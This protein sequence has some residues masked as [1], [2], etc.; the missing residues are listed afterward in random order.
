MDG[1]SLKCENSLTDEVTGRRGPYIT[2]AT[3]EANKN[4]SP[5]IIHRRQRLR[6]VASRSPKG[7]HAPPPKGREA[8]HIRDGVVFAG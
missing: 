3:A 5:K 4:N 6:I 7:L 2:G 1:E 8:R